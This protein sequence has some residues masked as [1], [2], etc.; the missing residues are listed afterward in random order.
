MG[1]FSYPVLMASDILIFRPDIIPVGEDQTQHVEITRE[2]AKTFNNRYG[3]ILKIPDLSVKKE[4]ARVPGIYGKRKMSKSLGNDI[5]IFAPE[6]EVKRQIMQIKT[7][8]TRIHP[9]DPGDP[10]KNLA[11]TYFKLL[12]Y[13]RVKLEKMEEQYRK[14]TIGDVE[15]KMTFYR[16]FLEYFSDIR[17]KKEELMKQTELIKEMREKGAKKARDVASH[18]LDDVME[19]VG[20]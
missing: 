14:G 7:D 10:T 1:L 13:D 20:V 3:D 19:A 5:P 17:K 16:F 9:T 12:E 15:I 4:V 11:F 2:I 8:P 6:T 18:V